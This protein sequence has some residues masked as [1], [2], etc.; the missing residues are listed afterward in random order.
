ME[1]GEIFYDLPIN[2]EWSDLTATFKIL[3]AKDYVTLELN[4]IHVM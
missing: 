2:G 4:E 3:Q 1:V